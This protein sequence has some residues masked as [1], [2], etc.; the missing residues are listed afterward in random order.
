[1]CSREQ[2]RHD[3]V[4]IVVIGCGWWSQGWHLPHL[5]QNAVNGVH[6]IALVD[7]VPQP[8]SVLDPNLKSMKEL[9]IQYS[10]PTFSSVS[11]LLADKGI[12]ERMDGAIVCTPHATHFDIGCQLL[13][14]K[15]NLHIFMEKPMTTD[16]EDAQKMYELVTNNAKIQTPPPAFLINHSANFRP[17][18]R[19][20]Q[21]L[22]SPSQNAIGDLRHVT[23]SFVSPLT[24]IFEDPSNVGWN[25]PSNN[26]LGNGFAWGQSSHILSWIYHVTK[27]DPKKVFCVMTHSEI[28]GADVCKFM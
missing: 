21:S 22:L 9:G 3:E 20:A 12:L 13:K 8:T 25:K 18:A 1:M 15:K 11:S 16:L 24:W 10:C 28:T 5:S 7:S 23:A 26:M 17:Q 6:I 14:G 2:C 27:L 4:N 19:M